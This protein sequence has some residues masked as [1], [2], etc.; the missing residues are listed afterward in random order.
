VLL[1]CRLGWQRRR[2]RLLGRPAVRET[3]GRVPALVQ[4]LELN[5]ARLSVKRTFRAPRTDRCPVSEAQHRDTPGYSP[6]VG[7][8]RMLRPPQGPANK[9]R[10]TQKREELATL[11]WH[12]RERKIPSRLGPTACRTSPPLAGAA[13]QNSPRVLATVHA[14]RF[15]LH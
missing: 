15:W 7:R 8:V 4:L 9:H 6:G 14:P 11:L 1:P 2:P 10:R 5:N 12:R 13:A 3:L